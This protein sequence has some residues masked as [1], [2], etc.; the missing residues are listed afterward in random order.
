MGPLSTFFVRAGFRAVGE[1]AFWLGGR[2]QAQGLPLRD[3]LRGRGRQHGW[4][5]EG[6]G[7]AWHYGDS[8]GV[9]GR[10]GGETL[11]IGHLLRIPA[12]GRLGML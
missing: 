8:V 10:G 5:C 11:S 6:R 9:A 2:R 4:G 12:P 3:R 1:I 7:K